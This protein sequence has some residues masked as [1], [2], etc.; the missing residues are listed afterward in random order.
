MHVKQISK[1]FPYSATSKIIIETDIAK[2]ARKDHFQLHHA[3][4]TNINIRV[5]NLIYIKSSR[6]AMIYEREKHGINIL[7]LEKRKYHF[8]MLDAC[9]ENNINTQSLRVF[10][11]NYIQILIN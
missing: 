3:I 2:T 11:Y 10:N 8:E 1:Q 7:K 6:I 9:Y 5:P 4:K